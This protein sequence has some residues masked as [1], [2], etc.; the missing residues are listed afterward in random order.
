MRSITKPP[1]I[2]VA[3]GLMSVCVGLGCAST[4]PKPLQVNPQVFV[5]DVPIPKGFQMEDDR[6]TDMISGPHRSVWHEYK[7]RANLVSVR[8]FFRD[9]MPLA[10]W[11]LVADQNAK[12]DFTLLF[13]KDNETCIVFFKSMGGLS[14]YHTM[15][16]VTISRIDRS[17]AAP[18]G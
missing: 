16:R 2:G 5:T 15:I 11:T 12:G 10:R 13:E 7:G 17:G 1:S 14:Y 8:N 6:S 9:Q 4:G 3:G 18:S